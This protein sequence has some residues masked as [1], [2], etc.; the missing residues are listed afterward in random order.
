MKNQEQ[1]SNTLDPKYI[2]VESGI[3]EYK[4]FWTQNSSGIMIP[5]GYRYTIHDS[6]LS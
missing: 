2:L 5:I 3:L 6:L 1:Y 4:C